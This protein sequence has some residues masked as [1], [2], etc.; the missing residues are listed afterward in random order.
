MT[1]RLILVRHGHSWHKVRGIVG[2]P[3]GDTG[4]T[5]QGR[6]EAGRLRDR[7]ARWPGLAGAAL[8]SSTLP[9]AIETAT[10]IAPA[11]GATTPTEHC[12]LCTYHYPAAAD[13]MAGGDFQR[14][15]ARPGG[16]V[17]RP[18]EEGNEAWAELL[19]RVGAAL[20]EIAIAHVG[21][22]A[23]LVAH[24]ETVQASLT[25]LGE[26]P[27]RRHFDVALENTSLT[28]WVTE[29]DPGGGGPPAWAFA[30][31]TLVRLNDAAHLEG[32]P[33]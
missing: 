29:D 21:R 20:F 9:R 22:T 32:M 5:E 16:G 18:Y 12:G 23:V 28:E 26:L 27:I 3:T 11:L 13:G 1:T 30:R 17:Y 31:W 24:T 7:L 15:L 19:V 6:A 2:G 33:A 25:A 10:I 8:Y 4:L 14:R